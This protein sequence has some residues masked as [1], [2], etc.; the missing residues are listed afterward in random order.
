MALPQCY[1]CA[2]REA[3]FACRAA[4]GTFDAAKVGR[5]IVATGRAYSGDTGG[6]VDEAL[7]AAN[8]WASPCEAEILEH[9]AELVWPLIIAA[10]D[11]CET[12]SDAGFVAAG[13][14]ENAVGGRGPQLIAGIE[15]LGE[16]SAKFRYVLS[17]IWGESGTDPDVWRRIGIVAGKGGRM[18]A[19]GRTPWDGKPVTVL[20][21]DEATALMREQVAPVARSLGLIA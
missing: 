6:I 11:A 17:G 5:A 3:G 18:S 4:D 2:H 16:R 1:D 13:L 8:E 19:D 7:R 14:V 21:D 20:D 10:N 12:P 9:H 15:A